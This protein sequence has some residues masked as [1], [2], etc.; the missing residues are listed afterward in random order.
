MSSFVSTTRD[1]VNSLAQTSAFH[2]PKEHPRC[3]QT[4]RESAPPLGVFHLR[5]VSSLKRWAWKE[6]E[7]EFGEILFL[8]HLCFGPAPSLF[9]SPHGPPTEPK[10]EAIENRFRAPPPGSYRPTAHLC[11]PRVKTPAGGLG[12]IGPS[13]AG[14]LR[15]TG[16]AGR[17]G[18]GWPR[19]FQPI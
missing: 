9:S 14:R 1:H 4:R 5:W 2:R 3:G 6:D 10:N 16:R 12:P 18:I 19:R 13:W 7:L 8:P 17:A 15:N 11:E